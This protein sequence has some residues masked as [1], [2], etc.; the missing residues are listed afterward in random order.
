LQ[1]V[2][3]AYLLQVAGSNLLREWIWR[4]QCGSD[5]SRR[6]WSLRRLLR[7]VKCE[8]AAGAGGGEADDE[9]WSINPCGSG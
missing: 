7:R 1:F 3:A 6:V 8:V 5:V 9:I 2:R 4:T